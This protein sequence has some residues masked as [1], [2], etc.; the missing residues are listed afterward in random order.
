MDKV[1]NQF[2]FELYEDRAHHEAGFIGCLDSTPNLEEILK[3]KPPNMSGLNM[4][5]F[6]Y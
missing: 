5:Y 3:I 1:L 4:T 2:M 6:T